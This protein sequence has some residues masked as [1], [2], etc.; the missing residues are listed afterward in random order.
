MLTMSDQKEIARKRKLIEDNME[1]EI[2]SLLSTRRQANRSVGTPVQ[3]QFGIGKRILG[4]KAGYRKQSVWGRP[5]KMK[6]G[7]LE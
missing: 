2:D 4:A 7:A 3:G 1:N 6:M 5:T